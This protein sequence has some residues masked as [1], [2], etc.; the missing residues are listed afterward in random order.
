VT[1]GSTTLGFIPPVNPPDGKL[2]GASDLD[3]GGT[4][5]LAAGSGWPPYMGWLSTLKLSAFCNVDGVGA[6]VFF[7]SA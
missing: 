4:S 1:L 7:S 5:D 3:C 6:V 2:Y